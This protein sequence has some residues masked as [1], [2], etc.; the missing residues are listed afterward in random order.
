MERQPEPEPMDIAEEADAYVQADFADVNAAFV[1]RLMHF[2]GTQT[3]ARCLD[4]GTGPG[5]IPIRI[6]RY[7]LRW[8]VIAADISAPM[9][10]HAQRAIRAAGYTWAVHLVQLDAKGTPFPS[11]AFDIVFSN[12]IL[13]HVTDTDIFWSELKRVGKPGAFVLVRDLARPASIED[14]SAIVEVHARAESALLQEE[15][16]RS[17]LAAYTPDEVRTQLDHAGLHGLRV[18]MVTDRHLDIFGR[19]PL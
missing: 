2:V 19:L 12:S 11:G 4:L 13:H 7:G 1:T 8:H 18:E 6:V 5:D 3:G 9:L 10:A 14:A 16:Y 15:F 17:L